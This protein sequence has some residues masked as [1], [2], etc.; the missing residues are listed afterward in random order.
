[1]EQELILGTRKKLELVYKELIREIFCDGGKA[2]GSLECEQWI[3]HDSYLKA[4]GEI[5]LKLTTIMEK[6][7]DYC[8]DCLAPPTKASFMVARVRQPG[9]AAMPPPMKGGQRTSPVRA[10]EVASPTG[11][12]VGPVRVLPARNGKK[13]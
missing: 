6:L 11:K 12:M 2:G 7:A 1:M 8:D 13:I 10:G 5:E 3:G 4:G 9:C